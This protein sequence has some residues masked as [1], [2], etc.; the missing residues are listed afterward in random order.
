MQRKNRNLSLRLKGKKFGRPSDPGRCSHPLTPVTSPAQTHC[1]PF[2]V[3]TS[4]S[5][6]L[7]LV[8][9]LPKRHINF[10]PLNDSRLTPG[11]QRE[12]E[13]D[14]GTR[15]QRWTFSHCIQCHLH[16]AGHLETSLLLCHEIL[17]WQRVSTRKRAVWV[18][19]IWYHVV[20]SQRYSELLVSFQVPHAT[21]CCCCPDGKSEMCGFSGNYFVKRVVQNG[22]PAEC[23]RLDSLLN[24]K[25][26]ETTTNR[27]ILF[28]SFAD[29]YF[30]VVRRS[31]LDI[32]HQQQHLLFCS[33]L[34]NASSVEHCDTTEN[35]FY[36]FYLHFN[37]QK[38]DDN[39]PGNV[40]ND[41]LDFSKMENCTVVW[42]LEKR[43]LQEA[44]LL[45]VGL[46]KCFLFFSG[47]LCF[48]WWQRLSC[49]I[50]VEANC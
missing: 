20:C 5:I 1:S 45:K 4:C 21:N 35:Y 41:G 49:Q 13:S 28:V 11:K 37:F 40:W 19:T 22:R 44:F 34:C 10:T 31:F 3:E 25:T 48:S 6:R 50:W 2:Y 17:Q 9:L 39:C 18:P 36:C 29:D 38:S 8:F 16:F 27:K 7:C 32:C 43:L 23:C 30:H 33:S 42:G 14:S 26:S 46:Q 12:Q 24:E 15:S 47:L